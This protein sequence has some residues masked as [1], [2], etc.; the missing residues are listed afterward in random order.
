MA[1]QP[2]FFRSQK[3][4]LCFANQQARVSGE[5]LSLDDFAFPRPEQIL[6]AR[7]ELIQRPDLST[8]L[9]SKTQPIYRA[10]NSR[11]FLHGGITVRDPD[12]MEFRMRPRM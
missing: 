2:L 10:K 11:S 3:T 8:P 7:D 4:L 6:N 1:M 9:S 5:L 12:I